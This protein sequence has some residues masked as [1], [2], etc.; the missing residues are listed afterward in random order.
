MSLGAQTFT[1]NQGEVLNVES[2]QPNA[3]PTGSYV[4][5]D[6]DVVVFGGSE[7]SNSPSIGTASQS[8]RRRQG[9]SVRPSWAWGSPDSGQGLPASL[10]R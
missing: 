6:K 8:Q 5:A 10:L 4:Q 1:L 7:A 2:N 9:C 3:D